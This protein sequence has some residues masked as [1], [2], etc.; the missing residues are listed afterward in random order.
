[1]L[2]KKFGKWICEMYSIQTSPI[3]ATAWCPAA[4]QLCNEGMGGG[5]HGPEVSTL[6]PS[7]KICEIYSVNSPPHDL[8]SPNISLAGALCATLVVYVGGKAGGRERRMRFA[9]VLLGTLGTP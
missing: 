9:L 3:R 6:H 7:D 5:V 2:A 8:E 4:T 1:M